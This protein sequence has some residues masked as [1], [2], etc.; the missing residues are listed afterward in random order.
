MKVY[1]NIL[2]LAAIALLSACDSD[3]DK[4]QIN[5]EADFTAPVIGQ[6]GNVIVNADN[7]KDENVIFTWTAA[8]FG[9]PVQI[10][11]SVYLTDG[12]N[13][14]LLGTSS[15][16]SL[17]VSKGDLN[18]VVINGLGASANQNVSVKAY[19]TAKMSGSNDFKT[20]QSAESNNFTVSTYA[21]ALKW[22]YLCGEFNSWTI[23]DAPIFWETSGG[24]NIYKCMVDFTMP[25]ADYSYFKVTAEQNWS[26]ANWGYNYL[27]P[28]W[29]CPEQGDSNL[30]LPMSEGGIFE[31]SVN[32]TV[33]TI[34]HT[35][36][37]TSLSLIGSFNGWGGDVD[38]VYD[39]LS[40]T[41]KTAPVELEANANVKVRANYAW[42][43]NWGAAGTQSTA[44]AGGYELTTG[45]D[46]NI[47]IPDAGTYIA[48]LHANRD[49]YVL[50]MVKQ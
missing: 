18:G 45:T 30:S 10:L 50:E 22:L 33:M 15:T 35:A 3:V 41:W 46:E 19:V 27:T 17:A 14:A 13:S 11:Y 38:F 6:C 32:T 31:I 8:D 29:D 2:T 24:S 49:P 37:G 39:S 9:L 16:T 7:S 26:G 5:S 4:L 40:S 44:I 21:A 1:K 34:D 43:I 12:T 48:V 47:V 25:G 23:G 28:S 36:I 20:V 42:D